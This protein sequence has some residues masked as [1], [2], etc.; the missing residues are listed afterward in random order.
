MGVPRLID[1]NSAHRFVGRRQEMPAVGEGRDAVFPDQPQV[2]LVNQRSRLQRLTGFR[3]GE[4][5]RGELA[6]FV[7]HQRQQ[8]RRCGAIAGFSLG[9]NA[10]DFGHAMAREQNFRHFS[11]PAK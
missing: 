1:R 11:M 5:R 7:V 9:Q 4:F 10:G 8:F 6:Q 3:L 2:G